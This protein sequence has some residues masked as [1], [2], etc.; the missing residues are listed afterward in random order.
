MRRRLEARGSFWT[1]GAPCVCCCVPDLGGA[2]WAVCLVTVLRFPCRRAAAPRP[3]GFCVQPF[4]QKPK[5]G[6]AGSFGLGCSPCACCGVCSG[7][8]PLG[9][10]PGCRVGVSVLSGGGA[11]PFRILRATLQTK[12]EGWA[13]VGRLDW[14]CALGVVP[15][16][17][18]YGG[19]AVVF[20]PLGGAVAS[21]LGPPRKRTRARAQQ[22]AHVRCRAHGEEQITAVTGPSV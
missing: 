11:P 15:W 7:L 18:E 22:R 21:S 2:S 20:A 16:G 10:L 3:L 17:A 14:V 8:C 4:K 5:A 9:C 6:S 1:G 19:R 13:L 12:A